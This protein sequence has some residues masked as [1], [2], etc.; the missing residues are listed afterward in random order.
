VQD[1]FER[2]KILRLLGQTNHPI[3][4]SEY[5]SAMQGNDMEKKFGDIIEMSTHTW[6]KKVY[7]EYLN[8]FPELLRNYE[9][10]VQ[11]NQ[12]PG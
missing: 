5:R 8:K 7:E 1:K 12:I 10:E 2:K 11:D 3:N 6:T 4:K 9:Q